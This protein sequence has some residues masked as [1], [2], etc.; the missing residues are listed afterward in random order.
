MLKV[1]GESMIEAGI[2]DGDLVLVRQQQTAN[3]GEILVAMLDGFETEATV[4]TFYKEDGH[5]ILQ[6]QNSALSPII[7]EDVS[8]LGTV[9]GVFRFIN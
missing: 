6:P 9:K 5:I 1:H 4:K 8:I 7:V 2:M 3:N